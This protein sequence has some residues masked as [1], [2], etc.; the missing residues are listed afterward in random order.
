MDTHPGSLLQ[1]VEHLKGHDL[2]RTE[3]Y[4]HEDGM[5]TEVDLN[6]VVVDVPMA[7]GKDTDLIE[8]AI[9]RFYKTCI[10]PEVIIAI[11]QV[12]PWQRKSTENYL[13]KLPAA[14]QTLATTNNEIKRGVKATWYTPKSHQTITKLSN[15][16][17]KLITLKDNDFYEKVRN[18]E[19]RESHA[20][21]LGII[22]QRLPL[23]FIES[24]SVSPQLTALIRELRDIHEDTPDSQPKVDVQ[25]LDS[26]VGNS[27]LISKTKELLLRVAK[28]GPG[29]NVMLIGETGTGKEVAANILHKCSPLKN[30]PFKALNC[31]VL[32]G[33][34][35]E[36][37]LFGHTKGAFTNAMKD[38]D[39]MVGQIDSDHSNHSSDKAYAGTLFLDELHDLPE[40]TQGVLLRFLESG[41]YRR[42][43]DTADRHAKIRIIAALQPGKEKR[44]NLRDDL[45]NRLAEMEIFLPTLNERLEDIPWIAEYLLQKLTE[46]E[47][48]YSLQDEEGSVDLNRID[49]ILSRADFIKDLQ[50]HDWS[51]G[52]VRELRN[53]LKRA[54]LLGEFEIN[55]NDYSLHPKAFSLPETLDDIIPAADF[56]DIRD[57]YMAAVCEKFR[58]QGA[59]Y[60]EIANKLGCDYRT[61]KSA[62]EGAKVLVSAPAKSKQR[63]R[64]R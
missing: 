1:V 25:S 63:A 49:E 54:A 60:Q 57:R 47:C 9:E 19:W 37:Q 40:S 33:E 36:S 32:S 61:L 18:Q 5:I 39:G 31:G 38:F 8:K 10:L 3:R 14:L 58:L 21:E 27:S 2:M 4:V 13:K 22:A 41:E 45:Y 26:L 52:N 51:Q 64:S 28:A 6:F 46:E 55:K 16:H 50:T 7:I 15:K 24:E 62:R 35:V 59:T 42:I 17:S 23:H 11:S 29:L 34:L 53:I 48:F 56:I 30:K 12:P 43:G 44:K 20:Q